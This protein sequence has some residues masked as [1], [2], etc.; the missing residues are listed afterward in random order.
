MGHNAKALLHQN[1]QLKK[2]SKFF[3]CTEDLLE[4][5]TQI[6][7]GS[8]VLFDEISSVW[9]CFSNNINPSSSQVEAQPIQLFGSCFLFQK[10]NQSEAGPNHREGD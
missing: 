7:P 2:P 3:L 1:V 10:L 9:L 4:I 8:M 5:G 6:H